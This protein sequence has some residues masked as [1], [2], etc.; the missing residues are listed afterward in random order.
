MFANPK[1]AIGKEINFWDGGK[2]GN[3]VGVIRDFN[4]YSLREPMAPVVLSTWKDVYQTIN[5]K[6]KPGSRKS[7]VALCRKI[8]DET[9]S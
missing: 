3:I 9:F 6:I 5:I 4:S 1:D 7:G 2:V 8:M